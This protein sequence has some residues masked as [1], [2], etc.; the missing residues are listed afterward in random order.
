[1]LLVMFTVTPIC[2]ANQVEQSAFKFNFGDSLN[3]K[4]NLFFN[5]AF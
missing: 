1:M 3:F 4:I 5:V 2:V